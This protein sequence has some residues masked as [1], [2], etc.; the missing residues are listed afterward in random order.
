MVKVQACLLFHFAL[1]QQNSPSGARFACAFV[2]VAAADT[3]L[4]S[5]ARRARHALAGVQVRALHTVLSRSAV[6]GAAGARA[7]AEASAARP[8]LASA[9]A[10]ASRAR[11]W[12]AAATACAVLARGATTAR[13]ARRAGRGRLV[14]AVVCACVRGGWGKGRGVSDIF[15]EVNAI[16]GTYALTDTRTQ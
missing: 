13:A 3:L 4:P 15:A 16:T 6:V 12:V 11:A 5:R 14:L 2:D 8:V 7:R 10:W 1:A 9:A